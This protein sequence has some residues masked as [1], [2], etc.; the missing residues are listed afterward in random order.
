MLRPERISK[1]H[2]FVIVGWWWWWSKSVCVCVSV[3]SNFLNHLLVG[4]C[5]VCR[6][7]SCLLRMCCVTVL[8]TRTRVCCNRSRQTA[9]WIS[10]W[11]LPRSAD[12]TKEVNKIFCVRGGVA[13]STYTIG[14]SEGRPFVTGD[15]T[16]LEWEKKNNE[17]FLLV[18]YHLAVSKHKGSLETWHVWEVL[19]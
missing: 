18:Y 13:W 16:Q 17:T 10:S 14:C 3:V 8:R 11:C 5:H 7:V 4:C 15:V 2:N 1:W 6:L 19:E 12:A 9:A